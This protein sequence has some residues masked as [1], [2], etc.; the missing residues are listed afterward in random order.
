MPLW[1]SKSFQD[2][3]YWVGEYLSLF[4]EGVMCLIVFIM[5]FVFYMMRWVLK[6]EK[7]SFRFLKE[8]QT[9]ETIWTVIP[10]LCLVGVAVPSMHLLYLMDEIG[11]PSFSFKAIGHQWYWSYEFMGDEAEVLG[12][13]SFMLT[14]WDYGYRLLDVDQRMVAPSNVDI[15]CFVSSED[16]IHS[17]AI[18]S[19]MLKVDAIP[20]RINEVPVNVCMSGVLY[21]QCSEIC[22]ANHSFMPIVIEFITPKFYNRWLKSVKESSELKLLS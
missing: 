2:S 15:R 12:F 9:V 19:C 20:G 4:Y 18:P 22:G 13:D 16:V 11:S 1:G 17:F 8:N 10:S 14:K 5:S 7:T 21:G 3:Y 6:K